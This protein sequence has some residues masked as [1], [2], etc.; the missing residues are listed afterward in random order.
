MR[1]GMELSAGRF[2][3]TLDSQDTGAARVVRDAQ[4]GSRRLAPRL[5]PIREIDA[6]GWGRICARAS[7]FAG[8]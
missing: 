3:M 7:P 6:R 1:A 4:H 5:S 2:C 8:T